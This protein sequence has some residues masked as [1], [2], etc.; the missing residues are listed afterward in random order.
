MPS[1]VDIKYKH[2]GNPSTPPPESVNAHGA[3]HLVKNAEQILHFQLTHRMSTTA[4][5][6]G[7]A[8][9]PLP[10]EPEH[11]KNKALPTEEIEREPPP[12]SLV[13]VYES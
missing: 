10:N 8:R 9:T 12:Q 1:T 13:L 6:R 4:Y 2:L 5:R 3:A 11:D 7:G